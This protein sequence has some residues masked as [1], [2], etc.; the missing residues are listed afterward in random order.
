MFSG[1][2]EKQYWLKIGYIKAFVSSVEVLFSIK[3]PKF[4]LIKS[5]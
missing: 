3:Y 1:V 5:W 4:S 2:N